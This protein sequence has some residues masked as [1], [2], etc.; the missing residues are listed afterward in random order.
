MEIGVRNPNDCFNMVNCSIKH[1]VDPGYESPNDIVDYKF[2]S[3]NF[4]SL[5]ESNEIDLSTTYKWDIIFWTGIV[6][7]VGEFGR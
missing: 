2:T 7:A 1:S 6:D 3:D 4:F 5:L